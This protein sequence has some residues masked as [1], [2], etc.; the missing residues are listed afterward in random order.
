MDI[1][2]VHEHTNI[3]VL[4]LVVLIIM[5]VG[6]RFSFVCCCCHCCW[7]MIHL[8]L[9]WRT[10]T[11][12]ITILLVKRLSFFVRTLRYLMFSHVV[13]RGPIYLLLVHQ[14]KRMMTE[15]FLLLTNSQRCPIFE[16]D[17]YCCSKLKLLL[18]I[19]Y[20]Y[21]SSFLNY[22]LSFDSMHV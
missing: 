9:L 1:F 17:T 16:L 6:C 12:S 20:Y 5:L 18:V 10:M 7:M 21:H 15:I 3:Q 2:L 13:Q 8:R 22:S 11:T 14:Q 19:L 4:F